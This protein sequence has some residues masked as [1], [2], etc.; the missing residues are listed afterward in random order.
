MT[1]KP[2]DFRLVKTNR[3]E[4][5]NID[6]MKDKIFFLRFLA[7]VFCFFMA[8]CSDDDDKEQ[9]KPV[10]PE[11]QQIAGKVGETT[12][13][14]F[15][16]NGAWKLTSSALW[17]KFLIDGEEVISCSGIAGE[18]TVKVHI[19]TD[20]TAL[21]KSYKS[22]ISLWLGGDKKVI[23]EITRPSTGYEVYLLDGE[24]N[25]YTE[26]NP[27]TI[28]YKGSSFSVKANFDWRLAE[29]SEWIDSSN[30]SD[31]AG[32]QSSRTLY[33]SIKSGYKKNA[34]T[35]F[36]T[37]INE[38]GDK[39]A[40]VPVKYDG[41]PGNEIELVISTQ[42][43]WSFSADG[44]TF[45]SGSGE[46]QEGP[47]PFSVVA[48]DDQYQ[49]VYLLN[50]TEYTYVRVKDEDVESN[51]Y[52]VEKNGEEVKV[53]VDNN[54][55]EERGGALL[56]FPMDIWNEVKD[57]FEEK[58]LPDGEIAYKYNNYAI[59]FKQSG[60]KSTEDSFTASSS[61]GGKLEV[62]DM[63]TVVEDPGIL[64]GEYNTDQVYMITLEGMHLYGDVT[65][66]LNG[67]YASALV[68]PNNPFENVV[69]ESEG[70]KVM[71]YQSIEMEPGG[72]ITIYFYSQSG[73]TMGVLLVQRASEMR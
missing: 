34:N 37:F 60:S 61:Y 58:V 20:A 33:A 64:W 28:A 29:W 67:A 7:L 63:K 39:V 1:K 36:L 32:E 3:L 40:N 16:A 2:G 42:W 53:S 31:E 54:E 70:G 49:I 65:V 21:N 8:A 46:P 12:E 30:Y 13:L 22:E 35:G 10:F 48:K 62:I 17:C 44:S 51:W 68:V 43:N 47:L 41:I 55:G 14:T 71:I 66:N 18:Q 23:Y 11:L 73:E 6:Y 27:A 15:N 69:I 50:D 26:E 72:T 9:N 56:V 19:G 57:D 25:P 4:K 52:H 45:V 59:T 38:N 5:L 24:G